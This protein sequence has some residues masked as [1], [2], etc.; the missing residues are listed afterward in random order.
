MRHAL[1]AGDF[2]VPGSQAS[3][4]LTASMMTGTSWRASSVASGSASSPR[5]ASTVAS[6]SLTS[7]G[8]SDASGSTSASGPASLSPASS[9]ASTPPSGRGG[10]GHVAVSV[11]EIDVDSHAVANGA[12]SNSV[13]M[14][15][16]PKSRPRATF[17]F[18]VIQASKDVT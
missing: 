11:Q 5:G 10:G 18:T 1:F 7:T 16:A 8:G 9:D 14:R 2:V 13:A 3:A 15:S 4:S 6:T 12:T 17:L